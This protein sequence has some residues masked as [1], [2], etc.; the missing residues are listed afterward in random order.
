MEGEAITHLLARTT[1]AS[2]CWTTF[3]VRN[4]ETPAMD[5]ETNERPIPMEQKEESECMKFNFLACPL[6]V[7]RDNT[8]ME[9]G[10]VNEALTGAMVEVFFAIRHYYL[11]DKKFDTF[12]ADIQQIKDRQTRWINYF[13]RFKRRNARERPLD[14]IDSTS[15]GKDEGRAEKRA[16]SERFSHSGVQIER[17]I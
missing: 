15:T 16:R 8:F 6:A 17:F 4:D 13:F 14:V 7:Y 1:I 10:E 3:A 11:C 9:P 2:D 12:Q 5:T